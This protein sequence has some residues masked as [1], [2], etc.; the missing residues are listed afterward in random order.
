MD[1]RSQI[2]R[3]IV[4]LLLITLVIGCSRVPPEIQSIPAS[5]TAHPLATATSSGVQSTKPSFSSPELSP[6]PSVVF[7]VIGDYGTGDHFE[8][9]VAGLVKS[10]QPEFI[11]TVG[12]NNYPSG[13]QATIDTMIGQ[14]YHEY[15]FPYKGDFGQGAEQN[16]FYPSLGNHDWLTEGAVPYLNYFVLPGNERY[17]DFTWG[18]LLHFFVLDSDPKEP[19]GVRRDSLQAAWLEQSMAN[20]NA[21]WKIVYMHHPPFSSGR[22][23]SV[24]YMRWPF[25]EWE[26]DAVLAGH[27]HFYERVIKRRLVYFVNGLGGDETYEFD[28]PLVGSQ[29]RFN[30]DHGAIRVEAT[31][32]K[33]VFQFITSSGEV[34]DTYEIER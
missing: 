11:I 8:G 28:N 31:S 29:V 13:S 17:Y 16:R 18:S 7:A 22:Q 1:S 3:G 19:D 14:F 6:E 27:D 21:T 10:W 12:D 26:A 25:K 15:I 4:I 2:K 9:E 32:R 34:I 5:I 23:G 30:A 33:L 24:E 20:S